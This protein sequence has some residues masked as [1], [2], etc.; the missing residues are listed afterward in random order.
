MGLRC[1]LLDYRDSNTPMSMPDGQVLRDRSLPWPRVSIRK[2]LHDAS[3][4]IS[5]LPLFLSTDYPSKG[6]AGVTQVPA[7]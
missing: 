6:R 7:H 2:S 5:F 3:F 1:H 4:F